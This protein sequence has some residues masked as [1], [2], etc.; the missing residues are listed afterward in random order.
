MPDDPLA[1]YRKLQDVFSKDV[2]SEENQI[3]IGNVYEASWRFVSKAH[4]KDLKSLVSN[5]EYFAFE[6]GK[7]LSRAVNKQLFL[8]DTKG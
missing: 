2:K 6:L 4:T 1:A 7:K 5:K 8:P 3:L